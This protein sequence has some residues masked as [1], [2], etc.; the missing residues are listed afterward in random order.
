MDK[1]FEE[2]LKKKEKRSFLYNSDGYADQ[3]LKRE[4][5]INKILW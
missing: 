3:A 2:E 4:K 1:L 5:T